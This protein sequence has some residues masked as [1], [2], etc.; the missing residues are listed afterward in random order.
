MVARYAGRVADG[1]IGTS[2]K[3]RELY[4]DQLVPAVDEGR[5]LDGL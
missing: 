1:F 5:R 2:G 4:A 3:G